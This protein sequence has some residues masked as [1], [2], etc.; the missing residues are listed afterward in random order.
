MKILLLNPVFTRYGGLKG[1]GGQAPPLGLGYIASYLREKKPYCK[2]SILDAEAQSLSYEE[3]V[4][5]VK[6]SCPDIIGITVNTPVFYNVQ[7]ITELIKEVLPKVKIVA[8]GPHPSAMPEETL[9]G[10]FID[11][12]VVGEGEVT[13]FELVDAIENK[14]PLSDIAGVVY[15]DKSKIIRNKVR[16][17]IE[18]LDSLPWPARDLMPHHLYYP[19]L[20][21]RISLYRATSITS[22]RGCPFNCT[23]CGAKVVW[24]RRYRGRQA[25]AVVDEIKYCNEK[26]GFG[27]FSFTDELLTASRKRVIELCDE[28]IR[29]RLKIVWVCMSRVDVLDMDM[30]KKMKM[31]GCR[32]IS[33]GVESGSQKILDS[34]NKGIT[35]DQI[36]RAISMTK[37]VGIKTHASYMI[38]HIGETED[39]VRQTKRLAEELNTDIAAFFVA[40]PFPGTE[41]YT[42]AKKHGYLKK[43]FEWIDFSP[44]SKNRAMMELPGLSSEK[45][46]ALHKDILKKYYLRPK[47]IFS[48]IRKIPRVVDIVNFFEGMKLLYRLIGCQKKTEC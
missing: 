44:L 32:E 16:P 6:K 15:K 20:T 31:A 42:Q 12:V 22:G 36:K 1:H 37:K 45:I 21:K 40:S 47:Y 28:I 33:F 23:F 48:Q 19:A 9:G 11:F 13:F 24:G 27:E 26:L 38:G 46:L 5:E 35:I 18:D 17:L 30:L 10:G 41:L 4:R 29:K 39:T 43:K 14:T 25:V 7:R 3:I 2:I 34:I 8:G